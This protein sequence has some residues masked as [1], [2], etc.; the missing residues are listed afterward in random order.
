MALWPK[1]FFI[2]NESCIEGDP[3]FPPKFHLWEGG[4]KCLSVSPRLPG[5]QLL[6]KEAWMDWGCS[7]AWGLHDRT[8]ISEA[9]DETLPL[10]HLSSAMRVPSRRCIP[11]CFDHSSGDDQCLSHPL[12]KLLLDSCFPQLLHVL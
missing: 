2:L 4:E 3:P 8:E 5:L 6:G 12:I 9:G 11:D 7:W 10:S 1:Q